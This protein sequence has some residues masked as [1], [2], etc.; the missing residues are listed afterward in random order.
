VG[1]PSYYHISNFRLHAQFIEMETRELDISKFQQINAIRA[2][3]WHNDGKTKW[4]LLEWAGAMCG[5][6]GEAANL[7]KKMRRLDMELPNKEAGISK[8]NYD[9]LRRQLAKE[10]T[11]S[12][13]YGLIILSEIEYD[14]SQMLA[15]VFDRKSF[16]YGFPERAPRSIIVHPLLEKLIDNI[17][18]DNPV[19]WKEIETKLEQLTDK[20]KS[21]VYSLQIIHKIFKFKGEW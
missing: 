21:I 10:V 12:I 9:E 4:S 20:E 19:D 13:I 8:D 6:S 2:K 16:E 14:A 18:N 11:D 7:A 5:E 1:F 17:I 15:E 3:R